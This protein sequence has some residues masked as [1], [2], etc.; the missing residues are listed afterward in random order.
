MT[1]HPEF[2]PSILR[3]PVDRVGPGPRFAATIPS[4]HPATDGISG[5]GKLSL[6]LNYHQGKHWLRKLL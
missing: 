1:N 2:S 4:M 3:E 6:I 5:G